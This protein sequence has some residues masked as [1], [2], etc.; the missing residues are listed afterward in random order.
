[1][2]AP[3]SIKI[4]GSRTCQC[5]R[6]KLRRVPLCGVCYNA[7]TQDLREGTWARIGRGFEVGYQ[8]AVDWLKHNAD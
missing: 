4:L 3:E 8:A 5:G 2:T 6:P 7:L 1:M